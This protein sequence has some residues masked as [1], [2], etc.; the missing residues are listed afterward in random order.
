VVSRPAADART[1][2]VLLHRLDAVHLH[3][4]R[5]SGRLR[6]EAR[7]HL[8]GRQVL[9]VCAQLVVELALETPPVEQQPPP[10][11]D[12]REQ[13]HDALRSISMFDIE[14]PAR[15]MGGRARPVKAGSDAVAPGR[16]RV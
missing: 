3:R 11:G 10:A 4:G 12:P 16:G 14:A 7:L 13:R 6:I 15:S 5:A 1:A 2:H 9:E 8:P